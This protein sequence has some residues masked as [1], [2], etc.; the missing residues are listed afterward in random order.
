[1]ANGR[2]RLGK[3]AG[4]TLGLVFPDG[5]SNTEV[6]LPESGELATKEYAD[7]K[8]AL[9][10]FIGTNQNLIANGYQKLPGGLIIQWGITTNI[11]LDT[12]FTVTFPLSFPNSCFTAVCNYQAGASYTNHSQSYGV[13]NITKNNFQIEN[14]TMLSTATATF[15]AVWFAIGY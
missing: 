15:P 2:F 12:R 6:V 8:V 7:L 11:P 4:G 1:M 9:E 3:Q 13:V 14:Q 10:S 5:I